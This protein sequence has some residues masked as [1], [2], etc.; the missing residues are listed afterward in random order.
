[1][2]NYQPNAVKLAACYSPKEHA[3]YLVSQLSF[4]PWHAALVSACACVSMHW[5]I[6]CMCLY[7]VEENEWVGG[8]RESA[9]Q[10]TGSCEWPTDNSSAGQSTTQIPAWRHAAACR[11]W[12]R[13]VC[14]AHNICYHYAAMLFSLIIT[15]HKWCSLCCC[16]TTSQ[17]YHSLCVHTGVCSTWSVQLSC[18]TDSSLFDHILGPLYKSVITRINLH[19]SL[20]R[21]TSWFISLDSATVAFISFNTCQFIV[22]LFAQ[23]SALIIDCQYLSLI[24]WLLLWGLLSVIDIIF[25]FVL[26]SI[27]FQCRKLRW[28]LVVL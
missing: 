6:K 3:D 19:H 7:V 27:K 25:V 1:M 4:G 14:H 2:Q 8:Y 13:K 11:R 10:R 23:Y 16:R 17:Q 18:S 20:S 28:L 15:T 5:S 12:T 9:R 22:L 21:V 24:L 26:F